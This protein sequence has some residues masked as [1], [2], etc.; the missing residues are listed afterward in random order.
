[1]KEPPLRLHPL[2]SSSARIRGEDVEGGSFDPALHRPFHGAVEYIRTIII[3]AKDK[4]AVDHDPE[5]LQPPNGRRI[6][7]ILV[8]ELTLCMKIF[9][10]DGLKADE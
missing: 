3:H 2:E 1:M 7:A 4:A 5:I 8:L 10:V 6:V 9:G